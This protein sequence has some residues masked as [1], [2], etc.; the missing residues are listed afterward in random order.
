MT[1]G[2]WDALPD[3]CFTSV[4]SFLSPHTSYAL[5]RLS[6]VS[7]RLRTRCYEVGQASKGEGER[8]GCLPIAEL[9]REGGKGPLVAM[10]YLSILRTHSHFICSLYITLQDMTS[11]E[12]ACREKGFP[13][14][15]R[16]FSAA[17]TSRNRKALEI[18]TSIDWNL[19]FTV[20]K[21]GAEEDFEWA[22]AAGFPWDADAEV[23]M[24]FSDR[25]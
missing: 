14:T 7:R 21:E 17:I 9:L 18:L 11:L 13:L 19:C 15:K 6:S 12:W 2:C 1:I 25:Y 23:H 20:L 10:E 3:D 5:W 4:L 8:R 16:A 22:E 24:H